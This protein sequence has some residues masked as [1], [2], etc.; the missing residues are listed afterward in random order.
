MD[1]KVDACD[2]I[3]TS[4]KK[5]KGLI[6]TASEVEV[7]GEKK[8]KWRLRPIIYS[9][10]MVVLGVGFVVLSTGSSDIKYTIIRQ[11]STTY[12]DMGDGSY[13]SNYSS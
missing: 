8:P 1:D 11:P 12:V 13:Y 5:P 6:R 10:L 7:E 9:A 4:I 2:G 3:M